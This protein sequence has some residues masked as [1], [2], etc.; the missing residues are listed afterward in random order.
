MKFGV[1]LRKVKT[2]AEIAVTIFQVMSLLPALYI[3]IISGY[4]YLMTQNGVHLVLFDA[5][6]SALP[7]WEV[8]LLSVLYRATSSETVTQFAL[9]AFALAVGL[10]AANV[11]KGK[12]RTAVVSRIVFAALI[13]GDL[14]FRL[15]PLHCN[16]ALSPVMNMIGFVIRLGCLALVVLD[17]IAYRKEPVVQ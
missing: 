14:V 1:N 3:Y 10:L 11:L 5:A 17:L 2:G 16:Q 13:L 15:L 12:P 4:P 9:L 6:I 8:M 7:R